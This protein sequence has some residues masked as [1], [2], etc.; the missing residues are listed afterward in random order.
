MNEPS[1]GVVSTMND[2]LQA[3]ALMMSSATF[4]LWKYAILFLVLLVVVPFFNGFMR[5]AGADSYD[6]VRRAV[7]KSRQIQKEPDVAE[8]Q[9]WT[10]KTVLTIWVQWVIG[11]PLLIGFIRLPE[12]LMPLV[13]WYS[14]EILL[15][16][17][18]GGRN[19][20]HWV[21][22]DSF[23]RFIPN[24]REAIWGTH[25]TRK[26]KTKRQMMIV[27]VVLSVVLILM[28]L[29]ERDVARRIASNYCLSD[30]PSLVDKFVYS[31][32]TGTPIEEIGEE[33]LRDML[34][35]TEAN[36]QVAEGACSR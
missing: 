6:W 30:V 26:R 1:H 12:L 31:F 24:G 2:G 35:S 25:G 36:E 32:R 21:M 17:Y 23:E 14:M 10:T 29:G 7:S 28:T 11:M 5:K 18:I 20:Y 22:I 19:V 15:F 8:E 27:N 16:M 13:L 34:R 33:Q 3:A 9:D 4:S